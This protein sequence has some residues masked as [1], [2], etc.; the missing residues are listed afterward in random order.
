MHRRHRGQD[1]RLARGIDEAHGQIGRAVAGIGQMLEDAGSRQFAPF[2]LQI[3][4][5]NRRRGGDIKEIALAAGFGAQ[6]QLDVGVADGR[7]IQRIGQR[8]R[9]LVAEMFEMRAQHRRD[10][11]PAVAD[12]VV[13]QIEL[14]MFGLLEL[15]VK[16]QRHGQKDDRQ[17]E[18]LQRKGTQETRTRPGLVTVRHRATCSRSPDSSGWR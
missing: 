7:R 4:R 16:H 10:Q 6:Q 18:E 9:R 13:Q 15:P 3:S 8:I 17:H 5:R 12:R 2:L 14:T 11:P 1:F